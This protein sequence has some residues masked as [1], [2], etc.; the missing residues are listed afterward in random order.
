MKRKKVHF[1]GIGGIGV[2][3][4]AQWFF[5][6]GWQVSGSDLESSEITQ[7]LESGGIKIAVGPHKSE[8]VPTDTKLVIY[9]PAANKNAEINFAKKHKI[10]TRSY[11]EALG[12]VTK[13]KLTIAVAGSHGKSTT[14]ALISLILIEAGFD[15]TVIVGTKL[16]EFTEPAFW[17]E[18]WLSSGRSVGSNF[19][20]G[21]SPIWIIEADEWK[22]SF[23][24]YCP[25][26]SVVTNIDKEHLDFYKT[27]AK[28]KNAFKK[29]LL[30]NAKGSKIIIN[31]DDKHASEVAA[32]LAKSHPKRFSGRIH[33]YSLAS[34]KA[35]EIMQVTAMP[36]KHNASNAMA[37]YT[38]ASALNI[39]DD[40]VKRVLASF[41]GA[42]RRFERVG[43]INEAPVIADY[44][45]HPT[46]ISSTIQA[47]RA[48]FGK[49]KIIVV[50]Q[51]HHYERTR[52][53]FPEL[54][55]ALSLG[56][57]VCLLDIYEVAGREKKQKDPRVHSF[58]LARTI[59]ENGHNSY[60]LPYPSQLRE[61]LEREADA[62]SVILMLGAGSI[63]KYTKNVVQ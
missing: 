59:S 54:Q 56:D 45:H 16:R 57:T 44:A 14:T 37:A 23:W 55:K 47:A 61:F 40:L 8:N 25:S 24:N 1:V 29:F 39:P 21:G 6:D 36:G 9:S 26:L 19:R 51:P 34:P 42:W 17:R 53:L 35:V 7:K 11:A 46:E 41:E 15:P 10:K 32:L 22:G 43:T 60:H 58:H 3:A 13:N 2:S 52:A 38:V 28:V 12:D 48:R 18:A 27:H 20:K 4:L 31:A 63:W 49:K 33:Y 62:D 50:F 5:S 30:N